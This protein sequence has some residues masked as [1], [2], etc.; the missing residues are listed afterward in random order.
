MKNQQGTSQLGM[1]AAMGLKLAP[2]PLIL[3]KS[4]SVVE[5]A[6]GRRHAC[7]CLGILLLQIQAALDPKHVGT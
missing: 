6:T 3:N 2:M 1:R 7:Q 5:V 4:E